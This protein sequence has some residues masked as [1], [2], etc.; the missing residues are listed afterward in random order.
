MTSPSW[1][2]PTASCSQSGAGANAGITPWPNRFSPPSSVNSSTVARGPREQVYTAPFSRTSKAGTTPAG[3]TRRSVTS[4]PLNT[5]LPTTTPTL[6]R[7]NQPKQSVRQSG[8]SPLIWVSI[9]GP[10]GFILLIFLQALVYAEPWEHSI[11]LDWFSQTLGLGTCDS[12]HAP[13]SPRHIQVGPLRAGQTDGGRSTRRPVPGRGPTPQQLSGLS[14]RL[15]VD[16]RES[17]GREMSGSRDPPAN[18]VIARSK[19]DSSIRIDPSP[20]A[21]SAA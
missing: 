9:L 1:P 3:C 11:D 10:S 17:I 6:R 14:L 21:R 12:K 5:K 4:V 16:Y 20:P 8:S 7:H 19:S 2:G 18:A 13:I 15:Q